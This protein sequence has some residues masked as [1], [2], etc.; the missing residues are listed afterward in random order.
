MVDGKL[1]GPN[2]LR[3]DMVTFSALVGMFESSFLGWL[4]EAQIGPETEEQRDRREKACSACYLIQD[5]ADKISAEMLQL[6]DHMEVCDAIVASRYTR[7]QKEANK[8]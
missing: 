7:A 2:E 6:A 5:L 1:I 3:S 8:G 4:E